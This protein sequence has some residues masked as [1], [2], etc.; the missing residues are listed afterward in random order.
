VRMTMLWQGGRAE[1]GGR[2]DD[3]GQRP[4]WRRW[5]WGHGDFGAPPNRGRAD[6]FMRPAKIQ[7]YFGV[8]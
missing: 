5:T 4:L 1:E 3:D 8:W 2:T 7:A 6:F